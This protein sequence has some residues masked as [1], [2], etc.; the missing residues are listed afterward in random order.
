MYFPEG[1][2][3]FWHVVTLDVGF[4]EGAKAATNTLEDISLFPEGF[5][6]FVVKKLGTDRERPAWVYRISDTT[7]SDTEAF[8]LLRKLYEEFKSDKYKP[9][10]SAG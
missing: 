5:P 4:S 1:S 8:E 6:E 3:F 9:L 10:E 2:D 7:T